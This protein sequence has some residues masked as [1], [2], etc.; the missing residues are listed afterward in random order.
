MVIVIHRFKHVAL[1]SVESITGFALTYSL[2]NLR[3]ELIQNAV[4][5]SNY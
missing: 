4:M 1:L 3:G 5:D 2:L